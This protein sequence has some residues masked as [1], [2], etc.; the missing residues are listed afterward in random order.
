MNFSHFQEDAILI[1]KIVSVID[2]WYTKAINLAKYTT[3]IVESTCTTSDKL[4]KADI[5][6]A[7]LLIENKKLAH[8][9]DEF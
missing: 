4:Q 2:R 1:I 5:T 8:A 9:I 7:R 3:V 6:S